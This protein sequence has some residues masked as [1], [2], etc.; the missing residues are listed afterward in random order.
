[1]SK[2]VSLKEF[3]EGLA[4]RL[5]AA[6]SEAAPTAR[7]GFEAG[8]GNWLVRLEGSGEVLPVPEI[9]SVPLT[10]DWFLGVANVRGVL[11]GV[12][13]FGAFLGV[14]AT[15]R[16]PQNR[17]LLVGQP[18]AVNCALLVSR[19]AGLRSAAD[20][21]PEQVEDRHAGWTAGAWRD[22]EGRVW[23]ELDAERLLAQQDFLDIAVH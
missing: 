14:G 23:R 6:A 8:G 19:L 20:L 16:G 1:M 11:Y 10:R 2:R 5:K 13:D 7:L 21:V 15:P 12:T 4:G 18:H 22:K 3:Q 9:Q 17:L